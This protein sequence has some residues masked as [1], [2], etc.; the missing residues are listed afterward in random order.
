M[1][2]PGFVPGLPRI[3]ST[4][5]ATHRIVFRDGIIT[6]DLSGGKM[7]K[8]SVSRDPTNTGDLGV[9]RAGLLM[10]KRTS[11]G[12]YAPSIIG[13]STGAIA[14]GATSLSAAAATVTELVRR[15]G[16]TGT[17]NLVGPPAASGIVA[18]ETITYSAASGTTI[19][20]TAP[21]NSFASGSLIMPTDGSQDILTV[22]PDGYGISVLDVDGST[23]LDVPFP[24][25]PIAG[26]LISANIINWPSDTSLRAWIMSTMSQHGAGK[27]IFD[28]TY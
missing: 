15:V 22:I 26:V 20:V 3:G 13:P 18:E 6:G 8:G 17:F 21:T 9:L 14:A 4:Y 25:F 10:G 16:S 19:T 11:G 1:S 12:L 27:F 28:H 5:T 7:I 2:L 23:E 24:L